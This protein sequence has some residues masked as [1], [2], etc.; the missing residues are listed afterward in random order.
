MV[1]IYNM[2]HYQKLLLE[3]EMSLKIMLLIIIVLILAPTL[4]I[5]WQFSG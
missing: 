4:G 5:L 3:V 2:L 1:I